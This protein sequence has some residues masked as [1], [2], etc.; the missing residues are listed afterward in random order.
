MNTEKETAQTE[1]QSILK[2]QKDN[3]DKVFQLQEAIRDAETALQSDKRDIEIIEKEL[4]PLGDRLVDK[5]SINVKAFSHRFWK[6]LITDFLFVVTVIIFRAENI[7]EAF[8]YLGRMFTSFNPWVLFDGSIYNVGLDRTEMNILIVACVVLF[9]VSYVK[10]TKGMLID[11]AL[12]SQGILFRWCT[13]IAL[14]V[15]VVIYGVYGPGFNSAA[16]IYFQF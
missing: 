3:S 10:Y 16:F 8:I 13:I 14:F 11:A 5:F 7:K 1:L 15:F 4:K 9:F 12:E 2:N 6:T